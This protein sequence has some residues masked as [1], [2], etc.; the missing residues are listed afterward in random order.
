MS[1]KS[2]EK[3][4]ARAL[5]RQTSWSYSECLRCVRT[6]TPE[7]IGQLALKRADELAQ[8]TADAPHQCEQCGK[9]SA[10]GPGWR[11]IWCPSKVD[12]NFPTK[13][14]SDE[15]EQS[16]FDQGGSE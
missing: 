4:K 5:Q 2:P 3:K 13:F 11:H 12:G 1:R 6:M 9:Q 15:C 16:W 14:C 10:W 8:E 7:Q